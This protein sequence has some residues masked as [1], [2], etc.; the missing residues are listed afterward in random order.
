M[1]GIADLKLDTTAPGLLG[2]PFMPGLCSVTTLFSI[3][4]I[5]QLVLSPS[6]C[7]IYHIGEVIWVEIYGF[8]TPQLVA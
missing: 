8:K 7:L 4:F 3:L 5:M 6:V 2:L 1:N